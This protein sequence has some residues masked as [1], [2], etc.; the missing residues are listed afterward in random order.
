MY[1]KR[2][3]NIYMTDVQRLEKTGSDA[4]KMLRIDKLRKGMPFMINA[5]ELPGN[6]CYLEFPDGRILLATISS[7]GNDFVIL[8]ELSDIESTDVR[9]RYNLA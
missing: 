4:V 5:K 1:Y 7:T 8:R 2:Q 6:Q 3:K 9:K